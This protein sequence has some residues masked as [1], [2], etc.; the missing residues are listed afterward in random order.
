MS[1]HQLPEQL[2]QRRRDLGLTQDLLA[3]RVGLGVATVRRIE[4]G[5]AALSIGVLADFCAALDLDCHIQLTAGTTPTVPS[6]AFHAELSSLRPGSEVHALPI[7]DQAARIVEIMRRAMPDRIS[8]SDSTALARLLGHIMESVAQAERDWVFEVSDWPV[9]EFGNEVAPEA[10]PLQS[11]LDTEDVAA[12]VAHCL[13]S[14]HLEETQDAVGPTWRLVWSVSSV[15]SFTRTHFSHDDPKVVPVL[16]HAMGDPRMTAVW[17]SLGFGHV[18]RPILWSRSFQLWRISAAVGQVTTGADAPSDDAIRAAVAHTLG[19]LIDNVAGHIDVAYEQAAEKV[20]WSNITEALPGQWEELSPAP[21][22]SDQPMS[23]THHD[24]GAAFE[25]LHD[26]SR[27]PDR[28]HAL[29]QLAYPRVEELDASSGSTWADWG[30]LEQLLRTLL[31][32]R[33]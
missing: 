28:L 2:R 32:E 33:S 19:T 18:G 24:V 11:Y 25:V 1:I 31:Q 10:A 6:P 23:G 7:P 5:A 20:V 9:D 30:P 17:A 29:W 27:D 22:A 14:I 15:A 12:E 8:D 3:D 13:D 16:Q 26:L 21:G 4:S